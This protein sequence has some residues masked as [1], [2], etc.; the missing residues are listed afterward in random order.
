MLVLKKSSIE[1]TIE[2]LE[3]S[4]SSE[5]LLKSLKEKANHL[6]ADQISLKPQNISD[7]NLK[8]LKE[9]A[10]D[11][12]DR[13]MLIQVNLIEKI[14]KNPGETKIN[15]L[16]HITQAVEL[17]FLENIINGWIFIKDKNSDEL[18]PY[19]VESVRYKSSMHR[20]DHVE[21]LC[22]ANAPIKKNGRGDS[23]GENQSAKIII[24][25]QA[26]CPSTIDELMAKNNVFHE[27][28]DLIEEYHQIIKRHKEILAQPN[29]QFFVKPGIYDR[30]SGYE[31]HIIN[32]ANR[33]IN[34]E[35]L[36]QRNY[37]KEAQR[38]RWEEIAES[39][40][41]TLPEAAFSET[42]ILPIHLVYDL[43]A[44]EECW[45]L[46]NALT[47]YIY[48]PEKVNLLVLPE[49]HR[50]LIEILTQNVDVLME[51]VVDGKSGG[52]TIML[53]G[54]PGLGKTLLPTIYSE[55]MKRPLYSVQAGQLGVT[56]E[57]VSKGL[58]K[59]YEN[60]NRWKAILLI[61]EADTYCRK[62]DNNLEYNAV[63]AAL[64]NALEIQETSMPSFFTTNRSDD[65]DDAIMSRCIAIIHFDKPFTE[66]ARQIWKIQSNVMNIAMPDEV[67]EE[68]LEKWQDGKG[69]QRTAGRDIRAILKLVKRYIEAKKEP[70]TFEIVLKM[71]GFKRF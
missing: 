3:K 16:R 13:S 30:T 8:I 12:K 45:V 58:K 14:R 15:S 32:K 36:L 67:I 49:D 40:H 64:L 59:I 42:P 47:E 18:T 34:D 65:I 46:S 17:W 51:D 20:E 44:H 5:E 11:N 50:E 19:T 41:K 26:D 61:D 52:C 24:F 9:I 39:H 22:Q 2:F 56:A 33:A 69:R 7:E 43:E 37:R 54:E 23:R 35:T 57:D 31:K 71:A 60:T 62:R 68:A 10:S 63:V 55:V 66:D 38:E 53:E 25:D 27:T 29:E 6:N 4:S 1:K 21:V 70:V 48:K 28:E